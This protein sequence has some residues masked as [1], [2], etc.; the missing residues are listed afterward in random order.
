MISG[1]KRLNLDLKVL[2]DIF[3]LL[4]YIIL[5]FINNNKSESHHEVLFRPKLLK[6]C[7]T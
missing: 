3:I 4:R 2:Y 5:N 7:G 6:Q 1:L